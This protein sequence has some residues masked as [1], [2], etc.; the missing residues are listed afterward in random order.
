MSERRIGTWG[1]VVTLVGYVIGASIFVLPAQLLPSLGAGIVVAYL[2]AALPAVFTCMAGAVIGNAFPVS[3]ATYV[4]VRDTVGVRAAFVMAWLLLWA[5]ALG[6]ALVAYGLADYAAYLWPGVDARTVA[7]AS[8]V[9]FLLVNLT[10][11]SVT[12]GVQGAMVVGFALVMTVFAA[13][14]MSVG[15]WTMLNRSTDAGAGD[16]L[17]GAVAAYFSYA[18]LQVLIDIGGEM[19][20]PERSIPRA[21][22]LSFAAVLLLYL[23]FML[24]LVLLSGT[25]G[26]DVEAP[27]LIGQIAAKRFGAVAGHA[28]V[29]SALLAAATSIN[30]ILFTQARDV[31]ALAADGLFPRALGAT[32]GG[33]PRF[34]VLALGAMALVATALGATVRD[35][36]VLTALCLMV[37]QG[38]LGLVVLRI[39]SRVPDAWE[40]SAFKPSPRA[41][42]I[43]GW[44][45]IAVSVVFFVIGATQSVANLA[46]FV[47]LLVGG[48]AASRR[49]PA[50]GAVA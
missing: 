9:A 44:G 30:G 43:I 49:L 33:V 36:A 34:A 26:T 15:D 21:L 19:R 8:V 25:P 23:S 2:V 12:V 20:E 42:A 17:G 24:A 3:G 35:Y 10:P 6:T 45:L 38:A 11:V 27:A 29:W 39:P 46:W 16:V 4:S 5:A 32:S 7:L 1:A 18:G 28:I 50:G 22:A 31:Q 48:I 47:V 37:I 40:R 14:G 13:A 41:M